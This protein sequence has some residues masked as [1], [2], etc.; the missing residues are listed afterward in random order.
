MLETERHDV[1]VT[2]N[3]AICPWA[4]IEAE[5]LQAELERYG[6][7]MDRNAFVIA[8]KRVVSRFTY[9]LTAIEKSSHRFMVLKTRVE[10]RKTSYGD[11]RRDLETATAQANKTKTLRA[12][13]AEEHQMRTMD[14]KAEGEV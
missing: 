7:V 13:R 10:L 5:R 4:R 8:R 2:R 3:A 14:K 6:E 11:L 9:F 1:S 12:E